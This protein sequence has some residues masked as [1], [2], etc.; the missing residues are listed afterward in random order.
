MILHIKVYTANKSVFECC[1]ESKYFVYFLFFFSNMDEFPS[2]KTYLNFLEILQ[3]RLTWK[4]GVS[5]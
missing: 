4:L 5:M 3:R 1:R 2:I